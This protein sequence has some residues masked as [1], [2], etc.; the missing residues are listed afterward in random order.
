MLRYRMTPPARGRCPSMENAERCNVR[1]KRAEATGRGAQ[2]G[3]AP[4]LPQRMLPVSSL[5]RLAASRRK[6]RLIQVE[7]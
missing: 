5:L 2:L 6:F 7:L 3:G 4:L 1:Q